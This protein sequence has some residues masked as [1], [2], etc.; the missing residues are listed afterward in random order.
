MR[1]REA[2]IRFL[3]S[4]LATYS[5]TAES[6]AVFRV[7]FSLHVLLFGIIPDI[8]FVADL[9][10][11]FF[12][13]PFGFAYLLPGFPS[14]LLCMLLHVATV[15][16]AVAMLVGY[17][18]RLSSLAFSLLCL[19]SY[20]IA[21]SLGKIN[22]N[23]MYL[24][25][26]LVFAFTD[27]GACYSVDAARRGAS[28]HPSSETLNSVRSAAALF[29]Y[30]FAIGWMFF[31]AGIQKAVAGWCDFSSQATLGWFIQYQAGEQAHQLLS[32]WLSTIRSSV[33]WELA[34]WFTVGFE[35]L[36]CCAAFRRQWML[37]AFCC[38][39]LFHNMVL[40]TLNIDSSGFMIC[41]LAFAR[42]DGTMAQ[43]WV[44]RLAQ[45]VNH[46]WLTL[47]FSVVLVGIVTTV[48]IMGTSI[49]DLVTFTAGSSK[50]SLLR[51]AI[52]EAVALLLA[53]RFLIR[54]YVPAILRR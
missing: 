42:W 8:S 15:M 7:L 30:A 18:T 5:T 44:E 46:R 54:T 29:C 37:L 34:D 26:P 1:I 38:A 33:F 52:I 24:L 47:S 10:D 3:A 11:S 49:I 45:I 12:T 13:P 9:P 16:A 43:R 2:Y 31:T 4:S 20:A 25:L 39:I 53:L 28:H 14:P 48:G 19:F 21:Y 32:P 35:I 41:Y 50:P 51:S 27:W 36:F 23:T 40:H 6:L 17:R 22:H